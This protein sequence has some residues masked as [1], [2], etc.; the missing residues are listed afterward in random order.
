VSIFLRENGNRYSSADLYILLN[1]LRIAG[2]RTGGA[3]RIG[4][5]GVIL[6]DD[7]KDVDR[8]IAMLATIGITATR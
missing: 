3:G 2:I 8:A 7:E 4:E 6:I 5:H 1:Q